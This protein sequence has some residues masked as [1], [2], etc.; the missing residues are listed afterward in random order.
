ME[1]WTIGIEKNINILYRNTNHLVDK[2]TWR[3][4]QDAPLFRDGNIRI[5]D[6]CPKTTEKQEIYYEM[7]YE[8]SYP[9]F[10]SSINEKVVIHLEKLKRQKVNRSI[11]P[12]NGNFIQTVDLE[13][14]TRFI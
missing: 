13:P 1:S 11:L 10:L 2:M 8:M 7:E 9:D 5:C 14:Y 3:G 12:D 4:R 6:S